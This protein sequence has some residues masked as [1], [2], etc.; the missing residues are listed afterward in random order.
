MVGSVR[1]VYE[2]IERTE[3]RTRVAAKVGDRAGEKPGTGA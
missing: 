3:R 1:V 2:V